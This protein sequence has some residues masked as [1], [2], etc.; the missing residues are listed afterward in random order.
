MNEMKASLLPKGFED[1]LSLEAEAEAEAIA[2]MMAV[3]K[4][5]GYTRIKPPLME[6]EETMLEDGVGS[7]LSDQ[8]FRVM[9][10]ESGKMLALRSDITPQ[11]ARIVGSRLA[12]APRPLRLSYANDV[13]RRR[14]DQQRT[15]R[16]FC[17][18]GC[19]LIDDG[20][21]ANLEEVIVLAAKGLA[22][23]G[24]SGVSFDFAL[25]CVFDDVLA[26]AGVARGDIDPLRA[27]VS[28]DAEKALAA[29]KGLDLPDAARAHVERLERVLGSEALRGIDGVRFTVD[30]LETRGFEYHKG[31]AFTIFA[32]GVNGELG[33][34]GCYDLG[35][36]MA[37]GFTF[38]MDT[39]RQAG[40]A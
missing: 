34:G 18:V 4:G 11:I 37:S 35:D 26:A 13:V 29:L 15:L 40:K 20:S 7:T 33:R 14:G 12:D 6:F 21:D 24:I 8:T 17:Q 19:E 30:P 3:F 1:L 25:P 28:G 22:A 39:V 32:Q 27:Q 5:A 36:S 31:I 2:A 10:A 23:L 16:Q 9:D 38:Y